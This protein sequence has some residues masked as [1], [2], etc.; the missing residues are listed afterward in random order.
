[1]CLEIIVEFVREV[2][3]DVLDGCFVLIGL[4]MG[5]YVVFEIMC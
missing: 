3:G 5:G 4:F 1:M 2:F